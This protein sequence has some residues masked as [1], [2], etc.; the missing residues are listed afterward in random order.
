LYGCQWSDSLIPMMSWE[1]SL[2]PAVVVTVV[3]NYSGDDEP[4]MAG[5]EGNT[6]APPFSSNRG[7]LLESIW[8]WLRVLE[9]ARDSC[10]PSQVL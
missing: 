2:C 3:A 7:G 4:R 5:G 10:P 9:V 1:L 6:G 8:L